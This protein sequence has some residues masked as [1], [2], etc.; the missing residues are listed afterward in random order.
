MNRRLLFIVK[1]LILR[2]LRKVNRAYP[3]DIMRIGC[4][5]AY[6]LA[7]NEPPSRL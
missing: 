1:M 6:W 4:L 2:T 7:I 3:I 5:C